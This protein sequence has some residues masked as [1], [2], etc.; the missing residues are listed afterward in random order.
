MEQRVLGRT[1]IRV[2]AIGMGCEG[3]EGKTDSECK[4]LL[5][6]AMNQ[7]VPFFDMYTSNP[8][9]RRNVG[10][11][12]SHYPRER[13]VIQGHLCTTWKN[14]QY[15]RTRKIDEVIGSF[16]E[17][18]FDMKLRSLEIGMIHYCDNQKDFDVIVNG[19]VMK[20][21][22]ELKH[23]GTIRSIGIST[24]NPDIAFLAVES[25]LIDVIM[26]SVNPAYDMLPSNEDVNVLF[27]K[28]TFER[29]YEGIDP[30]RS[31]LYQACQNQG[32]ALTVMKPFAG[33]LLLDEKQSPFGCAMTPVQCISYCLDR[34][35][36]ASVL[37]GMASEEEISAAVQYCSAESWEKDYSS[38]LASAPKHS[39]SG[40]CMYCGHCAPCAVQIDI[41]AVNKYL[42]LAQAQGF[43][44]ET[45]REHYNLLEHHAGEC[46]ACGACMKNCPFGTD[47]ISKM[48]QAADVF[49]K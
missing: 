8:K 7:G 4:K 13:F 6:F 11:A 1:G 14:G 33:G 17:L 19:P 16:E 41:A 25:G 29:V 38:I 32:I 48:K 39:F 2:S 26:L 47:I 3:F 24:H 12:L 10:A 15:C 18:M 36:V 37:G 45:V 34:P 42:D 40:H 31:R 28:G 46:I 5:D 27:E 49:G 21:A 20:Y 22:K 44:P 35:G 43:V 9:V 23:K 30:K